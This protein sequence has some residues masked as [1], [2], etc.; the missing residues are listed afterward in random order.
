MQG[1]IYGQIG[2]YLIVGG[3][4]KSEIWSGCLF[5]YKFLLNLF[6][7]YL[8]HLK[9]VIRAAGVDL[10]SPSEDGLTLKKRAELQGRDQVSEML[11]ILDA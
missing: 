4:E 10:T 11:S 1:M 2:N 5:L 8:G 7:S 9:N 3:F 6:S